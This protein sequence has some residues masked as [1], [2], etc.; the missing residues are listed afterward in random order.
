METTSNTNKSAVVRINAKRQVN[1]DKTPL[2][3]I[4]R[5]DTSSDATD[6]TNGMAALINICFF[7]MKSERNLLRL[8]E[9]HSLSETILPL[10]KNTFCVFQIRHKNSV[11]IEIHRGKEKL[12]CF[13]SNP[14]NGSEG[15]V[16][17]S[18]SLPQEYILNLKSFSLSLYFGNESLYRDLNQV[19]KTVGSSGSLP[20]FSQ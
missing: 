12:L 8:S 13:C 17:Q 14:E 1:G 2:I 19:G 4:T 10:L 3:A 15:K 18:F 16:N 9:K 11:N 20:C 6:I 5:M 7:L